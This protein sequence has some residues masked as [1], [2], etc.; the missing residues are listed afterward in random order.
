MPDR[1]MLE[2]CDSIMMSL[3]ITFHWMTFG[4][5]LQHSYFRW[6]KMLTVNKFRSALDG[7]NHFQNFHMGRFLSFHPINNLSVI[8]G[9]VF[10]G[11]TSTKL[12]LMFLLKDTTQWRR[13]GSNLRTLGLESSTLPL[14]SHLARYI[15]QLFHACLVNSQNYATRCHGQHNALLPEAVRPRAIVHWVDHGTEGHGFDYLPKQAWNNCF[16]TQPNLENKMIC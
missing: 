15:I 10:L 12:G 4:F 5:M 8:K 16:I 13:W 14:R 2:F 3:I 11:W 7:D 9:W 6:N 1:I